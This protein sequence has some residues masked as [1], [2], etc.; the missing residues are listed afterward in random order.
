[1]RTLIACC[2]LALSL[3]SCA[4]APPSLSAAGASAYKKTQVVKVLD[5]LRDTAIAA[6]AQTPP[7]VSTATTRKIVEAHK[8]ALL[9]IQGS[10]AGWAAAVGVTLTQLSRDP[11]FLPA[12]LQRLEPY[13]SIAAQVIKQVQTL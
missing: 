3:V 4:S 9:T 10:D 6:N 2:C 13:F 12:E 5:L 8:T 1:M 11:S 7:L